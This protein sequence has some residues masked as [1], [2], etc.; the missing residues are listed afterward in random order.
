[1]REF[2]T[3]AGRSNVLEADG[4]FALSAL[5]LLQALNIRYASLK[6]EIDGNRWRE[7]DSAR[8]DVRDKA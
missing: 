1:M 7:R 2:T 8:E 5:T 3:S 6:R 4:A